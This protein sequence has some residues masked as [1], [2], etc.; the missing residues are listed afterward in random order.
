MTSPPRSDSPITLATL[1]CERDAAMA[2][3]TLPRL[4]ANCRDAGS[5]TIFEDGSLTERSAGLLLEK[6]QNARLVRRKELDETVA[7]TLAQRPNSRAYWKDHPLA[8]K[9]LGIPVALKFD[10]F[11]FDSDILIIKPV[12]LRPLYVKSETAFVFMQDIADGYSGRSIDLKFRHG[13]RPLS[14]LNAGIMAVPASGHDPDFIEW[15]LGVPHFRNFPFLL[16]QTCWSVMP[17]GRPVE[18]IDPRLIWCADGQRE[19]D[20]DTAGIHYIQHTKSRIGADAGKFEDRPGRVPVVLTSVVA[21][22]LGLWR[23]ARNFT[24]RLVQR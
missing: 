11:Y 9:L 13:L 20:A 18:Y 17:R 15:F 7:G 21:P 23:M 12:S 1:I 2:A 3:I 6:L 22:E 8:L 10:F 24:R 5:F 4:Q 14:C 19:A 16:E